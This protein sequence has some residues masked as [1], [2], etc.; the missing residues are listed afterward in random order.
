MKGECQVCSDPTKPID[1]ISPR[2]LAR[3]G[4]I[5]CVLL[6]VLIPTVHLLIQTIG[7]FRKDRSAETWLTAPGQIES[8]TSFPAQD[9]GEMY[10]VFYSFSLGDRSLWGTSLTTVGNRVYDKDRYRQLSEGSSAG[11]L[12]DPQDPERNALYRAERSPIAIRLLACGLGSIVGFGGLCVLG[13][14]WITQRRQYALSI[15]D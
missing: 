11:V 4:I 15:A 13:R 8:I 9:F 10:L 7:D 14:R 1:Q 2:S 5:L 12:Y 6:T 3:D